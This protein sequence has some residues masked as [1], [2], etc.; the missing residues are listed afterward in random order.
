[1]QATV[2]QVEVRATETVQAMEQ[3]QAKEAILELSNLE[4]SLVGGG[5]GAVSFM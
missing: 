4:L 2:K 1:M 5:V 3:E